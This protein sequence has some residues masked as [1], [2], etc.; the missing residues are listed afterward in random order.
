M[1]DAKGVRK[2][3]DIGSC[4]RRWS[5]LCML[6]FGYVDPRGMLNNSLLCHEQKRSSVRRRFV[7]VQRFVKGARFGS[8]DL[9]Y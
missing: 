3:M 2:G 9:C 1:Y 7:L 6:C 5:S 8:L 4:N